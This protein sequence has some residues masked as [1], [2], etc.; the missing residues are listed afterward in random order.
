VIFTKELRE[1]K[2]QF[3]SYPSGKIDGPNA[4]AYAQLMRPEVVYPDFGFDHVVDDLEIRTRAPAWLA[5][6]ARHGFV[7]GVLTQ[8]VGNTVHI[9]AD[10]VEEGDVGNVASIIKQA[11]LLARS[12]LTLVCP[13]DHFGPYN[14]LGLRGAVAKYPAT[15]DTGAPLDLG[16]AEIRELLAKRPGLKVS[17]D[18]R[19]TVNGFA[20]GYAYE[21][22]RDGT[23]REEPRDGLY[24]CLIEGLEC[25]TGLLRGGTFADY[26]APNVKYTPSGQR[27]ISALPGKAPDEAK[28]EFPRPDTDVR[29]YG[30]ALLRRIGK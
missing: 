8:V 1:L 27:Y 24:R 10:W 20:A 23:L 30:P 16:R 7:T 4:L 21:F 9:V 13:G 2:E 14:T 19:W 5:L 3:L 11:S 18:A 12:R 17:L 28:D 6:N 25:F 29:N 26:G 22:G 15:L